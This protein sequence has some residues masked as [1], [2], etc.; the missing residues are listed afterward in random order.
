MA[1]AIPAASGKGTTPSAPEAKSMRTAAVLL[2]GQMWP[3]SW[4]RPLIR[5]HVIPLSCFEVFSGMSVD[6]LDVA[7][8]SAHW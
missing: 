1:S 8:T 4:S 3:R 6:V 5:P 2:R 7:A